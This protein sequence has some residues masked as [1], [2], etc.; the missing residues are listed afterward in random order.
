MMLNAIT[1]PCDP[2]WYTFK[3]HLESSVF[4]TLYGE[5]DSTAE[6]SLGESFWTY[7]CLDGTLTIYA[8]QRPGDP[9][10]HIQGTGNF[11]N[12]KGTFQSRIHSKAEV[13]QKA[14]AIMNRGGV[15][16]KLQAFCPTG[17][18]VGT[19]GQPDSSFRGATLYGAEWIHSYLCKDGSLLVTIRQGSEDNVSD[20]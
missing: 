13:R 11:P 7:K 8:V 20:Q 3:G 9:V 15:F 5:P 2:D 1:G 19:F 17:S 12:I 10:V 18:W 16:P 6:K 14:T 4:K